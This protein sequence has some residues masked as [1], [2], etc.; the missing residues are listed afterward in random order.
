MSQLSERIAAL[1]PAQ[2]KLFEAQMK[3]KGLRTPQAQGIPRCGRPGPYPLTSDQERLWFID[4]LRPGS[5]AYNIGTSA[6]IKGPLDMRL[7]ERSFDAIVKRHDILR[8]TFISQDGIPFQVVADSLEVKLSVVDFMHI[9]RDEREQEVQE[10]LSKRWKVL[11]N[12]VEGPLWR[13]TLARLD[14]Q[15]HALMI[16]MHHIVTDRWSVSILWKE[17]T[18]FYDLF[19]KGE[20]P[21]LPELPIQFADYAVWQR[22]WMETEAAQTQ[23]AYW[24]KQLAGAPAVLSL[25]TDRPR[26]P[27]QTYR[28]K[29]Q[30]WHPPAQFWDEVRELCHR[31]GVTMFM[32]TLA[33]FNILLYRYT[34]QEDINVG[35]PFAKRN[36]V[37][38]EGLIGYLLNMLVFR[39]NL[40]GNPS[41]REILR[42]VHDTAVS[43]YAHSEI[44]YGYIVEKVLK[45]RDISR[46]PLF[47][48]SFV[49]IDFQDEATPVNNLTMNAIEVDSGSSRFDVMLGL[50]DS[51]QNPEIIFE[52]NTD[53][54][55]DQTITR[56]MGH[57]QNLLY[58]IVANVGQHIATLSIISEADKHQLLFEFNDTAGNFP[59]HRCLHQLFEAQ[60]EKT[61][62]AVAAVSESESLT[63][64]ELNA[65]ANQLAHHLLDMNVKAEE[66]IGVMLEPSLQMLVAVLGV[67]KS[68]AAYVPLDPAY[69]RG[70]LSYMMEDSRARILLSQRHLLERI[71]EA[72]NLKVVL[73]DAEWENIAQQ[74]RANPPSTAQPQNLAYVIYTSGSTG[75][76]KGTLV[77]HQSVVNYL[78]WFNSLTEASAKRRLPLI[79]SLSFDASVKQLFAPLLS[80]GEVWVWP[81]NVVKHPER[82]IVALG[83]QSGV[84][85]NCVP[86]LWNAMLDA[87]ES[88]SVELPRASLTDLFLGGDNL[89]A[90]LIERTRRALPHLQ[91][92]NLYGPTEAT[93][94]AS[95][96]KSSQGE[97]SNIGRPI[98]NARIYILD[99]KLQPVP[100]G[101]PGELYI[102]GEGVARGYLNRA[103]LTA[104]K[105]IP[106]LFGA[107][108]GA[109]L[110]RT[111]DAA[112]YLPDGRI[113]FL[114]RLDQ[115]VKLR[116]Y[117]IE[118]GE[119][120]AVL[121]LHPSIVESVV[122]AGEDRAGEKQL[123]AYVVSAGQIPPPSGELR[124]HL[125][126][127][128]P[129]YMLPSIFVLLDEMPRTAQGKIDRRALPA[130][131]QVARPESERKQEPPSTPT[132][133]L[134]ARMW[135]EVL[136]V[137]QVGV[138]DNFFELGGHS[139]MATQIIS[140]IS[141]AFGV[142]LPLRAAFEHP[143]I[144]GLAE[145]IED[146]LIAE[147][148]EISENEASSQI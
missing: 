20:S 140:R 126:K 61:P 18:Y 67:L 110:Y 85:L 30:Y 133:E 79:S 70:R 14:E 125:Q 3:Q 40:K 108:A 104:G 145:L 112:R 97:N 54:F 106:D 87:L 141:E 29:R 92:W 71:P 69:P 84:S 89:T 50:R 74:S 58:S 56:M 75:K 60:A 99:A 131:E 55:D 22:E 39:T 26:P 10:F 117:R 132:E 57:F 66:L 46:N 105:F 114:G 102:G 28:G 116:G 45:E 23:L 86:S 35:S 63:Y 95:F 93:A 142:E 91:I 123:L 12:L 65:R 44:P 122:V 41:V 98:V 62:E 32:F 27:M 11:F 47:Q 107:Q 76:P 120:E 37:E 139:L 144:T 19:S 101:I 4:R 113:E 8:T 48:V 96:G 138:N 127:H 136:R 115:Q 134:L 129:D 121:N 59:R 83:A 9:P 80:G 1:S 90:E 64:G 118:V 24:E 49:L 42:R 78:C 137:E 148:E 17:L 103:T 82:L 51:P 38:T 43:A 73:L 33:A 13:L 68:G 147:L 16:S 94:N 2:R 52:Y 119:I 5:F 72:E 124:A 7:L 81:E 111:G 34:G 135:S 21:Q 88:G 6:Y 109:R 53:L 25:P 100:I 143:T 128:L 146:S 130:P 77:E 36:Q 15:F 31:E